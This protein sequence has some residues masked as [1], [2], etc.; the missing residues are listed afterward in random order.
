[1]KRFVVVV[2]VLALLAAAVFV[3]ALF[4]NEPASGGDDS[5][6]ESPGAAV[7]SDNCASC[8]GADGQGGIGPELAGR[9]RRRGVPG[10]GGRD[11]GRDQRA[12][13]MPSF[14]DNLSEEEIA[15]V[16]EYTRTELG[17]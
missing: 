15:Q 2:E 13:A 17:G 14:G 12:D 4:A 10:G 11:R 3:I 9:R 5:A 7:Y 6:S 8:H 1:M 16:V